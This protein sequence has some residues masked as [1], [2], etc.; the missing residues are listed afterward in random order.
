[1]K[2][3]VWENTKTYTGHRDKR[4]NIDMRENNREGFVIKQS[5]LVETLT[6][7]NA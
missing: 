2:N 6:N 1:M 5:T 4:I 3:Q 7:N